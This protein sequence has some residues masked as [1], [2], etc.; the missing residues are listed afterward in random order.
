MTI[1]FY[2]VFH[3]QVAKKGEQNSN[4]Q[5]EEKKKEREEQSID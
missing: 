5:S 1:D 3:F 2:F 4:L